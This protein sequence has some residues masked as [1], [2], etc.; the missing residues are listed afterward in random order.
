MAFEL[1]GEAENW[2]N[3]IWTG[4]P[5]ATDPPGPSDTMIFPFMLAQPVHKPFVCKGFL[6]GVQSLP[7]DVYL[8]DRLQ[9]G[10]RRSL[11]LMVP[12]SR[13][14]TGPGYALMSR[15]Y[16]R[17]QVHPGSLYLRG[18]GHTRDPDM[19]GSWVYPGP[20]HTWDPG[21]LGIRPLGCTSSW[22]SGTQSPPPDA[23]RQ[24]MTLTV[25]C[26][27]WG[28]GRGSSAKLTPPSY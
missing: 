23:D 16:P 6:D 5:Q 28:W 12:A 1:V 13:M 4:T 3:L 19:P 11:G 14:Y 15:V 24:T 26:R 17:I 9:R 8:G 7:S 20:R 25:G 21:V 2:C 27:R 10:Q 22:T 18:P